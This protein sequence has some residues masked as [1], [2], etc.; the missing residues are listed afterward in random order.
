MQMRTPVI[1]VTALPNWGKEVIKSLVLNN[2]KNHFVFEAKQIDDSFITVTRSGF[3]LKKDTK[4]AY[5]LSHSIYYDALENPR[6]YW[7]LKKAHKAYF[8]I[9]YLNETFDF[10]PEEKYVLK[11]QS[12]SEFNAVPKQSSSVK[13]VIRE[14]VMLKQAEMQV[15]TPVFTPYKSEDKNGSRSFLLMEKYGKI[16]LDDYTIRIRDNKIFI[17][18]QDMLFYSLEIVKALNWLHQEKHIIHH[19]VHG[20]NIRLDPDS[21]KILFIDFGDSRFT[22][23][24]KYKHASTLNDTYDFLR[25]LQEFW[26]FREGYFKITDDPTNIAPTMHP[27]C[28]LQ[29]LLFSVQKK[30]LP[31]TKLGHEE[32][33]LQGETVDILAVKFAE[34]YQTACTDENY[35][36]LLAAAFIGQ[37]IKL[38]LLLAGKNINIINQTLLEFNTALFNYFEKKHHE[39]LLSLPVLSSLRNEI[40]E[41]FDKV[42]MPRENW[43]INTL[44]D[45]H[46]FTQKLNE[47]EKAY[48]SKNHKKRKLNFFLAENTDYLNKNHSSWL[49]L[50]SFAPQS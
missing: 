44:K 49:K 9:G 15:M 32:Y 2:E 45:L 39:F 43:C 38:K 16:S 48:N 11:L 17:S 8:V 31:K 19:D 33:T 25:T 30:R 28:K 23:N 46:A 41:W 3:F 36:T 18:I 14:F 5:S 29:Q 26:M 6:K 34:I 50:Q 21:K 20:G 1:D 37:K 7:V 27:W 13:R 42:H 4:Q 10:I 24:P 12:H 40:V 35:A 22:F 47:L